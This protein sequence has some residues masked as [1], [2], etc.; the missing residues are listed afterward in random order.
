MKNIKLVVFLALFS[1]CFISFGQPKEAVKKVKISGKVVEK[2][3]NQPLEYA[4]ISIL[5]T[6]SKIVGGGVTS[7][8]GEFEVVISTGVYSI[9]IEFISFK[10]AFLKSKKI[11][12]NTS[13]GTIYLEEDATQLNEVIVRSEKTT[14]DI[15]LDKKVYNVGKDLMVKGGTVSDVLDNIPSV[16]VDVEGNITLRGN[17]NVKILI[18]GRPSNAINVS[19]ALRLIPAD[20]IEKVEI[21]TNPSARYDAEGGGG[22][23]NIILK[24]GKNLGFNG[25]VITS[26]GNPESYGLSGTLNYKTKKY[27]VFTT[28]GY[29]YQNNPGNFLLE[30]N[31]LNPQ[32]NSPYFINETRDNIRLNKSYNGNLGIELFLDKLTTWTTTLNYRKSDGDNQDNV[33]YDNFFTTAANDFTRTRIN[34][35]GSASENME[36]VT[37]LLKKFDTEGHQ[38]TVDLQFSKN[39]DLGNATIIDSQN[40]TDTTLNDQNQKRSLFQTDYVLPL[41]KKGQFEAGYRGDFSEQ[42]TDVTV[43]NNLV[44]NTNFTNI[45]EYK[46]KVNALY[47]QYGF[48]KGKFSY[49][50]GLRWEDSNIDVNQKTTAIYTNKRYNNFFPSAFVTYEIANEN[51]LSI[52]YS[53]RINRPRGRQ[54]NPFSNYSS[55]INIFQ[56]NP[57]INP[58][59]T[60]ALDFGYLKK[61]NKVTLSTSLYVNKTTDVFQFVRKESG[62]FATTIVDGED[63]VVNGEVTEI[64]GGADI[65][66]PIII[67]TPINLSTE[68]RTGFEFTLNYSPYKWWRLNGN[69]NF[70]RSETKGDYS[71]TNFNNEVITQSFDNTTNSWFTRITSKINLPYKIDW[72]TNAN[73]NGPENYAQGRRL[74]VFSANLAFS[75]DVFKEKG[76]VALSISDVLNSRKRLMETT[77]PNLI[78]SYAEMQWRQRQITLSFTYRFNKQKNERERQPRMGA[79]DGNDGGGF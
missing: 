71:Y 25:T 72:Q 79:P 10:S 31:Y 68:Y 27:N 35:E 17:E 75:K 44:L 47:T 23:L 14:V 2:I 36:L 33:N 73:Y 67:S 57:D 66:I 55:N 12:Q 77:I 41:G 3:T 65:R 40:G 24:K 45:L 49:L 34:Y 64:V 18:D 48:K 19:E 5:D 59:M 21:V 78:N 58:A 6:N 4:T 63:V 76:T 32:E 15:K 7:A 20:A 38:L 22:I 42:T 62:S 50:F 8:K 29:S 39:T 11:T 9:Q 74:G 26:V 43:Y 53:K 56:G 37:G 54:L 1:S 13:L 30:T 28:Q 52:S 46:E 61:W 16:A 51:T 69:F 60:D 70:F